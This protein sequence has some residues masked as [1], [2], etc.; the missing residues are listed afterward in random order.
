MDQVGNA[1]ILVGIVE[2]QGPAVV[3]ADIGVAGA[4]AADQ[5]ILVQLLNVVGEECD[6]GGEAHGQAGGQLAVLLD[7]LQEGGH[8]SGSPLGGGVQGDAHQLV[9]D[10]GVVEAVLDGGSEIAAVLLIQGQHGNHFLQQHLVHEAQDSGILHAL[11]NDVMAAQVCAQGK[12]G[13]CAVQDA[14]LALLVGSHVGSNEDVGIQTSL[15]EG[16]HIVELGIT[17][18]DPQTKD[19]THV[20]Q[21]VG[22]AVLLLQ[23][24]DLLGI[25]DPAGNDAV[26]QRAAEGAGLVDILAETILQAPLVDVLIDALQQ[27]LAVVV[28]Q[29]AGQHDDTLL[30]CL[31]TGIQDLG[32]LAGEGGTGLV[33]ERTGGIV[34]DTG[35]G[36]VGNDDL[37]IV[38]HGDLHHLVEAFLLIGVQAT[39]NGGNDPLVIHLLALFA[40]AQ[41]QGVQALL[42][43]DQ[44][45]QAGSNGLH[46]A[47][48]AVPAGLLIGQVE[49]V[50]D[51]SPQEITFTELQ[52]L[53]GCV[54][55][56]VA[57]VAGLLQN[58]IIELF[59]VNDSS[60]N[61]IFSLIILL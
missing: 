34:D 6:V 57:G 44:L 37:Q 56:N 58:F 47:A 59:H 42:L 41:V 26:N 8:I 9:V 61:N 17:L 14:D 50:V 28:D 11:A 3:G 19:L 60:V 54:L 29:L 15:V 48:L 40:A 20:Q 16:Q 30:A 49:P 21:G 38:G 7:V 33:R 53:L 52:N 36:G 2:L 12:A 1:V 55:Q 39:G 35:L 5:A 24:G 18:D 4:A 25:T 23:C 13:V 27:F 10:E 46:Q 32:Q 45:C 43:I 31:V 51:E 22:I